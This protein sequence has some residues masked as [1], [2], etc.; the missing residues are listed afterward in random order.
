MTNTSPFLSPEDARARLI[1]ELDLSGFDQAAQDRLIETALEALMQEV[2]A[3]VFSYIPETEYAKVEKLMEANEA[4]AVQAIITKYVEPQKV[5]EIIEG[6]WGAGIQNYKK[7]LNA[8][9]I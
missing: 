4:D 6:V 9:S 2:S 5:A 7:L 1:T 8:R 3:A